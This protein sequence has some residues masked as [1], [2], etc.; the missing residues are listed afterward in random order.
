[1]Q[2]QDRQVVLQ[3]L[4]MN[5]HDLQNLVNR[6]MSYCSDYSIE[7]TS[8]QAELCIKHLLYV[9]QVN[10]YMNLT[11]IQDVDEA[12]ILHVLDSLLLLP[13]VPDSCSYLLDMG[14]GAGFPGIPLSIVTECDAVLLDSVGKKVKAVN[15]FAD[16]LGLSSVIGVHD[17][18]ES[19]A[20]SHKGSFDL[21]V[22]RAL[23]P[24]PTLIEYG[25]PF[26]KNGA[27]FIITKGVPSEEELSS[28]SKVAE[29]CGLNLIE[30]RSIDLPNDSGHRE[31]FVYRKVCKPSVR[32]PRSVGMAKRNPL[33]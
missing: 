3:P 6:L 11:R 7:I 28:G 22:G 15:A 23:A 32:L 33:A 24:L 5:E 26:L 29:I 17:R 20:S 27:D 12:L 9:I 18:L 4:D 31:I 13:Y 19:F 16:V 25:A 8:S 14:T 1:M 30:E 2:P 21:V 10:E